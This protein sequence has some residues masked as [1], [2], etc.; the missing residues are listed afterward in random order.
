MFANYAN[1]ANSREMD[2]GWARMDTDKNR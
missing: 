2:H 1:F